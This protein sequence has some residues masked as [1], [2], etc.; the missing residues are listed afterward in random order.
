MTAKVFV[1]CGQA[2]TAEKKIAKRVCKVLEEAGLSTYLAITVQSLDDV[3]AITNDLRSSDYYLFIDFLRKAG[4]G[5]STKKHIPI[6][7]FTHQELAL[8]HHLGFKSMIAFQQEGAP[9]E[10]FLRYVHS[11]PESF[12][13]GADLVRK[14]RRHIKEKGW[15]PEFSRNLVVREAGFSPTLQYA[16]HTGTSIEKHVMFRRHKTALSR[17]ESQFRFCPLLSLFHA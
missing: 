17:R 16:D 10:G 12:K 13:N 15:T 1:S 8:A 4:P 7:L 3:M 9:L 6:S 11:N 14:L 2:T 5:R